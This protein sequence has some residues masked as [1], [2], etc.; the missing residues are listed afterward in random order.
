MTIMLKFMSKYRWAVVAV[1]L[2]LSLVFGATT[3]F[4]NPLES[5]P[6]PPLEEVTVRNW[7]E[8]PHEVT[9][10]L[11][12]DGEIVHWD[13]VRLNGT[14]ENQNG[15]SEFDHA[16]IHEDSLGGPIGRYAVLVRVDDSGL[17]KR[18]EF[19]D[20]VVREI[21][22]SC[23]RDEHLQVAVTVRY[24]GAPSYSVTCAR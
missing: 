23:E 5:E 10:I 3:I 21:A 17:G 11:E 22:S 13:S 7:H 20:R 4:G 12:R 1:V 15:V 19:T 8:E 18:F 9:V 16:A 14:R 2:S 24:H 6:E